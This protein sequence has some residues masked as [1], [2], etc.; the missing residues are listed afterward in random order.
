L[1]NK[2]I[3]LNSEADSASVRTITVLKSPYS[4]P[5]IKQED[6]SIVPT[7]TMFIYLGPP[8]IEPTSHFPLTGATKRAVLSQFSKF[9]FS[10][11]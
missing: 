4:L 10:I 8:K 9:P 11:L 6:V 2:D 1:Q 7:G 3:C 5:E